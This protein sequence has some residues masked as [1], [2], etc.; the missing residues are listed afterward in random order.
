MAEVPA[1]RLR[2]LSRGINLID[3][4]KQNKPLPVLQQDIAE[5]QRAGFRHVRI[6]VD[7]ALVWR[8]DEPAHLDRVVQAL[9]A[10]HLGV[11]LCVQSYGHDF[12][13]EPTIVDRWTQT[14]IKLAGHYAHSNP[15]QMFFE[16]VN[17]PTM[18]DVDKWAPIQEALR[19]KVRAIVPQHTLLLTGSPL[20]TSWALEPLPKSSDDN[21]VY[22]IHVYQ[23]MIITHQGADWEEDYGTVH[24]LL[25]PPNEPNLT[26]VERRASP[27]LH[28]D[29]ETYRRLGRGIIAHEIGPAI[30]WAQK[31]HAPVI[32]TEFGVLS[33]AGTPTRAAWLRDVRTALEQAGMGWSLWE[34]NGGFGLKPEM[35]LG[36]GPLQQA[37][38]LCK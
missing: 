19:Q 14:W 12:T 13:G 7:P 1:S 3:V 33:T 28:E 32:V 9:A 6:F 5:V 29:F 35:D 37:L 38:G 25:Y 17:E 16:L 27:K 8:S 30:A 23:P 22:V 20:S 26:I 15:E 2:T 18:P 11:I 24:G 34:Y 10:A 4:F 31:N 21:V 36:C